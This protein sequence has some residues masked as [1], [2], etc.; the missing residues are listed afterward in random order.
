MK[1]ISKSKEF[2]GHFV[3]QRLGLSRDVAGLQVKNLKIQSAELDFV[4]A[5]CC[6]QAD[7]LRFARLGT[8]V[9]KLHFGI[10]RRNALGVD[11]AARIFGDLQKQDP[12]AAGFDRDL[13]GQSQNERFTHR[14]AWC[15]TSLSLGENT[16]NEG[17]G[18]QNV[19]FQ[20]V[21][22]HGAR[23]NVASSSQMRN[24]KQFIHFWVRPEDWKL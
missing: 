12:R 3:R 16:E 10:A 8:P 13:L 19:G 7:H 18:N 20:G 14:G 6:V 15:K 2:H 4:F 11:W 24:L 21:R 23:L 17:C 9:Q 5:S 1:L 22:F